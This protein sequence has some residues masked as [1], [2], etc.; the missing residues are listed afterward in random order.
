MILILFGA[1]IFSIFAFFYSNSIYTALLFGV[2]TTAIA[3]LNVFKGY[4]KKVV[5][6]YSFSDLDPVSLLL[7]G[8]PLFTFVIS[9]IALYR[10]SSLPSIDLYFAI[11]LVF[12]GI[13]AT[14]FGILKLWKGSLLKI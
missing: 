10:G 7:I 5:Q 12:L 4:R 6:R 2:L 13:I 8:P 3:A 9:V 1:W 11:S 14:L